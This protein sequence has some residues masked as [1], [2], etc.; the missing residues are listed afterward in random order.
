MDIAFQYGFNSHEQFTRDFIKMFHVT[1]SRYRK[2][3]ISV[4]LTE[5][6]D[7]IERN[8]RN[9]NNALVVDHYCRKLKEIKLLGKEVAGVNAEGA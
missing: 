9:K 7:I 8:F 3:N 6:M 1:P 2:E 4:S 5:R